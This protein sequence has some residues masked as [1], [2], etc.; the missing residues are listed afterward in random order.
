M[1]KDWG[2]KFRTLGAMC[3]VGGIA[4]SILGWAFGLLPFAMA[5][6]VK[7][8]AARVTLIETG[9]KGLSIDQKQALELG[10]MQQIDSIDVKLKNMAQGGDYADLRTQMVELNQRLRNI[11][12]DMARLRGGQTP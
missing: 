6:D 1:G 3:A 4:L 2:E 10:L 8:L 5:S 11:R 12:V 7:V 9:F